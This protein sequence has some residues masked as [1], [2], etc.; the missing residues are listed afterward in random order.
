ML[1]LN[2]STNNIIKISPCTFDTNKNINDVD[3]SHNKIQEIDNDVFLGTKI[4]TLN[5]RGNRLTMRDVPLLQAP[6]L[7]KLDLRSHGIT[8][9]P[10]KTFRG[11]SNLKEFLLDNNCSSL[12]IE[13][14]PQNSVFTNLHHL[15][16]LDLS[17][18]NITKIK[19]NFSYVVARQIQSVWH[20]SYVVARQIQSTSLFKI[21][22]VW[23]QHK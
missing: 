1:K 21:G 10:P 16:R 23:Q 2:L 14:D 5:L 6:L 4:R 22:S 8:E 11:M 3:L 15:S 20:F 13:P 19:V 12:P 17:G 7:E 18:N 9:L